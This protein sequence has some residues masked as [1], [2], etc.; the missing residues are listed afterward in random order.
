MT[1]SA[2]WQAALFHIRSRSGPEVLRRRPLPDGVLIP[3]PESANRAAGLCPHPAAK[4]RGR[5]LTPASA[6]ARAAAPMHP[7]AIHDGLSMGT[8][9][10]R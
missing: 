5:A 9:P 6:K 3:L 8:L 10:T 1:P 4:S 2:A 7:V